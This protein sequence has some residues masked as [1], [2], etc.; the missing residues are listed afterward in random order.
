[1]AIAGMGRRLSAGVAALLAIAALRPAAAGAE[2][3][4]GR[5]GGSRCSRCFRRDASQEEFV[6][7]PRMHEVLD[8]AALPPEVD[9]RWYRGRNLTTANRNQHIPSYCGACWAFGSTSSLSDRIRIARGGT[10]REVNIA[11]QVVLNCDL[12]D[13][14]CDG[15]DPLSAYRFIKESGGIPEESC[16]SYQAE[17]RDTGR[18]CKSEDIC[19]DCDE[20]GCSARK[21]YQVFG[22][23]EYG[24]VSGEKEMMAELQ[25]GP[26][27][28]QISTPDAF[29]AHFGEGIFEDPTH[30]MNV[31]HVISVVGYGTDNGKDYWVLRNSWGS[32]WGHYGWARI[33]R[34]SN[35]IAIETQC[36][37][38]TPSNHGEPQW[39]H[40]SADAAADA[41]AKHHPWEEVPVVEAAAATDAA[42]SE[43]GVAALGPCRV[44]RSD[45]GKVG[46]ELIRGRR[47]HEHLAPSDLPPRW[48]WANVSGRSYATWNTN[49]NDPTYCASCWA[50]GV[51]SA[52][53]DRL[54]VQNHGAWPQVSLSPQVLINC[55][56]GGSCRGGDPAGAY[57]YIHSQGISDE[58]CQ[59]YQGRERACNAQ[60]ICENC[61][62]DNSER[63]LVWP[64]HCV[65]VKQPILYFLSEYGSVRGAHAMKAEI[66]QRGP[67]GC[68]MESTAG[69]RRYSGGVYSE[70]RSE[71]MLNH[72]VSLAGWGAVL[73]SGEGVPAGTEYWV[74]RNS[75]GSNW[76]EGGWFRLQMHK[77]NLGVELD[78]DWGVPVQ[79]APVPSSVASE[80]GV[81]E[82]AKPLYFQAFGL[83]AACCILGAVVGGFARR[84]MSAGARAQAAEE[85]LEASYIRVA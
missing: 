1:M 72:E 8:L 84:Q 80:K 35:T 71:P 13:Q 9:W 70:Y 54:A 85:A 60:G 73:G 52:L 32:Y 78:C 38:A 39:R 65:A 75:W 25:R 21:E 27:A 68:G 34:G 28:C 59:N 22:I 11:V 47:P 49:E 45:W 19:R 55:H 18:S 29:S 82:E 57:A 30:D 67:I 15:G 5:G 79:G 26:I 63:G 36:A 4:L 6:R 76:G 17:G 41:V 83:A 64:G 53:S 62:P 10:G 24:I 7:S 23:D 40:V 20:H 43:P 14:G 74:G 77:R 3:L 12:L 42:S 58:T 50:H 48:N 81:P 66:Y 56:G 61:A 33:A 44:V 37:W 46:G 16:Q 2:S 69:F 51:T 31:D